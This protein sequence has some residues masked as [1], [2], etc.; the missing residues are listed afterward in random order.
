MTR[1]NVSFGRLAAVILAV[2]AIQSVAR[3]DDF[4]DIVHNIEKHYNAK[5]KRIPFLGLAGFAVKV[6]RPAGVKGFKFAIFEDQDFAA[7]PRDRVFEQAL[8]G[9]LDEKWTPTVSSRDR[10]SGNRSYVYTHKAGKDLEVL[11]VTISPR[12]A[13]VV[14]AKINP[15][16]TAKFMENPQILG[17]SLGGGNSINGSISILDPSSPIYSGRPA[18][19]TGDSSIDSLRG[20][21]VNRPEAKSK[22]VLGRESA[23]DSTL[24][25]G[26]SESPEHAK[27]K[28]DPD[29]IRL[30]ARLINLNVKATDRNG[31]SLSTLKKEDFLIQEDG[32]EQ[33]IFYF[34]PVSAPINVVLLLDLSGSTRDNREVMIKTA[35]NFIDSL[36]AHDRIAIAAFTRKFILASDFTADKKE[37]KK[38]VEKMKKISGGTAFYDGMWTTLDLL[39]RVKDSRKAIVVLTDGVDESLLDSDYERSDHS[40]EELLARLSEEDATIYPIYFN[41]EEAELTRELKDPS[42]TERRRERIERRL[43]PNLT[44]HRQIEQLAEESAGSVFVV[45]GENEL[46]GIYQRVAAE[47]RL[48]YSLA[49]APTNTSHDGKF[50]KINVAVKQEGAV[51]RT[52]RG[53]VSR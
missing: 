1:G 33:Q 36:G 42:T 3:A 30:E 17:I 19:G 26:I 40:F 39:R 37:L 32:V 48:I 7:G 47:L 46:D 23:T 38:S 9:S 27:E 41:R 10:V 52:R 11:S 43:K 15:E 50:R 49:Y 44:A 35:K 51:V 13:I 14:Q 8:R 4:G 25:S 21:G 5:Q 53:Y 45:A 18:F 34:E 28:I 29:A 20:A 22:P 2:L 24:D 12:Q 6:I 31:R 16:S